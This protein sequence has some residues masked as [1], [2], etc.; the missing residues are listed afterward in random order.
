MSG[1]RFY[2]VALDASLLERATQVARTARLR[3]YD[4][5]Y[6]ALALNRNAALLTLDSEVRA[7]MAESFPQVNLIAPAT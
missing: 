4:A 6:L 3:A 1:P 2:A 5:V 7:K